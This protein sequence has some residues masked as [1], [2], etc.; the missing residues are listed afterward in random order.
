MEKVLPSTICYAAIQVCTIWQARF[1]Y[2][3]PLSSRRMSRCVAARNGGKSG[4]ASSFRASMS[5]FANN[6]LTQMIPGVPKPSNGG[7]S[8]FFWSV[9]S[10]ACAYT[11]LGKY[12]AGLLMRTKDLRR[13]SRMHRG[14]PCALAWILS[15]SEGSKQPRRS[16]TTLF[17]Y[18]K[19]S[20]LFRDV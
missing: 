1:Y 15:G 4:K 5:S 14:H 13:Q 17:A 2:S 20:P 18:L 10:Y 8:E 9:S 19:F 3:H 7:M 16:K 11:R 12:L 6:S